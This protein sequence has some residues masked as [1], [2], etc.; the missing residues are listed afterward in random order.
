MSKIFSSVL[1]GALAISF[2]SILWG[3]DGVVL[4]PR[5]YNL[6]IG[7]VVFMLHLIPF[8]IM[9]VA[10]RRQFG[11]LV[12]FTKSD[13]LI[14]LLI[15]LAG[16]VIGTFSI[17][18]ALFLVEF[19]DLTIVV[20]LQKLQP[21]FAISLAAIMLKEQLKRNFLIWAS[22]AIFASYF[23]T[24]GFAFPNFKTESNMVYAAMYALLAAASFGSATVLGK[25][26]LEKYD[27][28]TAT[29]YRYAF[30]TVIMLVYVLISGKI[31]Q[32][33][34]TT[35]NNWIIFFVIA[36]TTGSGAILLYYYG[37]KKVKAIVA[38]ICE[39][40][41]PFSA[42]FF[43]YMVNDNRLSVVQWLSAALLIFAIINL[44]RRI[45]FRRKF[46]EAIN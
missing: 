19:R 33:V 7:Y 9:S 20:L 46:K 31:M 2:A 39:L 3:F 5:L 4:T 43:D 41:F 14:F 10:L 29:F 12:H 15:S 42:I 36:L 32:L 13:L 35:A 8:I 30:T 45:K 37:L 24:F 17:V 1:G 21:V 23:L 22:V 40:F 16:G 27:F 38:A 26:I 34:E 11:K 28:K 18:K 25:K 6:D 44:N